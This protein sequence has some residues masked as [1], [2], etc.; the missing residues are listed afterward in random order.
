ME[1]F[2]SHGITREIV[3][4]KE[5]WMYHQVNIGFNYR[6]NDIE[7]ALGLSQL[8]RLDK[9]IDKRNRIAEI[10]N[11]K[12]TYLN[13]KTPQINKKVKSSYH[14]YII[15]FNLT[16][17]KIPKYKI[18]NFLKSKNIGVQVHYIPIFLQP[19]YSKFGFKNSDFPEAMKFYEEAISIPIY[20]SLSEEDQNYVIKNIE[21]V[22]SL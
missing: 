9:Y 3:N 12:L 18:F 6:M 8:E 14:L 21:K 17:L 10:Y 7:A 16:K 13:L 19:F 22:A 15:R 2:R 1:L 11:K 20:P 4:E 5:P